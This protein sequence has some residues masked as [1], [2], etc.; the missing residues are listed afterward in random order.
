MCLLS[1]A[2]IAA[3]F[4]GRAVNAGSPAVDDDQTGVLPGE[5]VVEHPLGQ[6]RRVPVPVPRD[7]DPHDRIVPELWTHDQ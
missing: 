5:Q 4:G 1:D 6:L 7:D 3:G 2:Q